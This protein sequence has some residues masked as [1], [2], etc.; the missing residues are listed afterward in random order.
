MGQNVP[1]ASTRAYEVTSGNGTSFS[2]PLVAGMIASLWSA[3]PY[4]SQQ[5]I[6]ELVQTV[7]S[8][9]P[10]PDEELGYGIPNFLQAFLV[11]TASQNILYLD[12]EQI[13]IVRGPDGG[14]WQL[15]LN[16]DEEEKGQM[17]IKDAL[18]KIWWSRSVA[19][20]AVSYTHL[21][22]PTNREV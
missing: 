5:D 3:L 9:Y 14:D 17:V 1:V 10:N 7:G 12:G 18:G 13:L 16:P 15:I 11:E 19:P 8:N 2:S 21:T 22:L 6:F 20:A 4:Y